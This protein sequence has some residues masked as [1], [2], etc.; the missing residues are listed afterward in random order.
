M[1]RINNMGKFNCPHCG[2][3]IYITD[4]T[5]C[6][7]CKTLINKGYIADIL[8]DN[9][10]INNNKI[11]QPPDNKNTSEIKKPKTEDN[12]FIGEKTKFKNK[13]KARIIIKNFFIYVIGFV[14]V[15][16]FIG[17]ILSEDTKSMDSAELDSAL[18]Q[19]KQTYNTNF[20]ELN[21]QLELGHPTEYSSDEKSY[22]L[23]LDSVDKI[24]KFYGK[25]AEKGHFIEIKYTITNTSSKTY[26]YIPGELIVHDSLNTDIFPMLYGSDSFDLEPSESVSASLFY[27]VDGEM[28]ANIFSFVTGD[29]WTLTY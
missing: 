14:L 24:D 26:R 8:K 20:G 19:F 16:I 27:N 17:S 7:Y 9:Q 23:T 3:V 4:D 21:K 22:K 28:Y 2:K 6:V 10:S 1:S 25:P 15:I 18:L 12:S 5:N 13:P 11:E 29:Y